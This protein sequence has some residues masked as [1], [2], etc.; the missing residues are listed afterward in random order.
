MSQMDFATLL[1]VSARTLQDGEQGRRQPSGAANA[2]LMVA[3]ASPKVVRNALL[4][5]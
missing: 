1:G 2:L 5:G 4:A 3:A